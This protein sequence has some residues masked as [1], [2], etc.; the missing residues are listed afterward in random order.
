MTTTQDTG[1]R[2]R[3]ESLET[4]VPRRP[5][6]IKSIFDAIPAQDPPDLGDSLSQSPAR[7]DVTKAVDVLTRASRALD[8][9]QTRYEAMETQAKETV[10]R[11][12]S[13]LAA[14]QSQIEYWERRAQTAEVQLRR[15]ETQLKDCEEQLKEF[16]EQLAATE[17]RAEA[18]EK[19]V[20]DARDWIVAHVKSVLGPQVRDAAAEPEAVRKAA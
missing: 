8:M 2:T 5:Q 16:D 6:P 4:R 19:G 7:T 13:E 17:R 10:E 14:A 12:K 18:A 15:C 3:L 11:S 1:F 9:M 20:S